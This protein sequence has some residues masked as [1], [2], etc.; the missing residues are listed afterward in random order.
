MKK[1]IVAD[2]SDLNNVG[3]VV[4]AV[5]LAG[6]DGAYVDTEDVAVNAAK[7]APGRFSWRKYPEQINIDTVRKR[8]WDAAK[9]ADDKLLSGSERQGWILTATGVNFCRENEARLSKVPE[10]RARQGRQEQVWATRERVRLVGE[11]AYQKWRDGLSD[12]I[13]AVEAERFFRIDDYVIGKSRKARI[14]RAIAA[15]QSDESLGAAIADISKL[16]RDI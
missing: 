10:F 4:L 14:E 2:K 15:F 9:L 8:L 11:I 13:S 16:V 3:L 12:S 1:Q 7:L 5:F 6:G